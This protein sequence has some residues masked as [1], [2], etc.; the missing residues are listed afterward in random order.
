MKTTLTTIFLL[1][2]LVSNGQSS[3]IIY[4]PKDKSLIASYNFYNNMA[5]LYIGGV[6][7]TTFP[8]QYTYTTPTSRINRIG[9]SLGSGKVNLMVGG[10]MERVVSDSFTI[11]PDF[12]VKVYPLR[13]ITNTKEG[14]DFILAINYMRGFSYGVGITIPFR[15]IY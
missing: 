3:D 2:T 14:F 15:G 4:T 11:R 12:W 7:T 8:T 9:L 10:Y 5:G 13:I 6:I 1:V